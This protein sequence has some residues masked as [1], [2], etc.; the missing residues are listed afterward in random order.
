MVRGKG[1]DARDKEQVI[2]DKQ[3]GRWKVRVRG[4]GRNARDK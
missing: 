3:R 2:R 1:R 4:K